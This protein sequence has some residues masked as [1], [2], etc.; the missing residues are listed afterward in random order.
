[1]RLEGLEPCAWL[2]D[3]IKAFPLKAKEIV[4]DFP[5]WDGGMDPKM[6][7]EIIK[8][9]DEEYISRLEQKETVI[10]SLLNDEMQMHKKMQSSEE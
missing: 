7:D 5:E 4:D 2:N 3:Q 1:M 6:K 10:N 8:H 9:E